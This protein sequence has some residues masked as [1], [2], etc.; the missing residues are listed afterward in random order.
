MFEKKRL[1]NLQRATC[2]NCGSS[3][4][5]ATIVPVIEADAS[6]V[7]HAVC[8]VCRSSSMVTITPMGSGTMPVQSDLKGT[9]FKKF[10]SQKSVTY[11]DILDLHLALKKENIWK[12]LHKKEKK[13]EKQLK[14]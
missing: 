1:E 4:E 14:A 9:E 7:V 10:I 5:H 13:Q 11:D 2:P 6:S 3:L 12:L 8:N